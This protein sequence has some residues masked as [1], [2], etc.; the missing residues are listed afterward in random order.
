ML[1]NA[2]HSFI[3]AVHSNQNYLMCFACAECDTLP[4]HNFCLLSF[5]RY[6]LIS[7]NFSSRQIFFCMRFCSFS[8]QQIHYSSINGYLLR[9]LCTHDEATGDYVTPN[10][11][12]QTEIYELHIMSFSLQQ[13]SMKK[14]WTWQLDIIMHQMKTN[15]KDDFEEQTVCQFGHRP[16]IGLHKIQ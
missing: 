9:W 8:F 3:M 11:S 15:T 12:R 4:S 7:N 2:N 13:R 6:L 16:I 14:K 10:Q 5:Y 1:A